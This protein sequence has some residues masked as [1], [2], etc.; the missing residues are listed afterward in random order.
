MKLY[1]VKELAKVAGVSVRT[2]HHYDAIGLLK[3]ASIG[4]NGYR[5]YGRE[6]L[7]RLQQILFYRELEFSLEAISAVLDQPDFDRAAA[8][9]RHRKALSARAGRY[10]RLVK[11]L[12]DTLAA[13]QGDADMTD[14]NLF[15]GF[16]PQK[17]AEYE[18]WMVDKYGGDTRQKIDRSKNQMAK[19]S[20]AEKAAFLKDQ[21]TIAADAGK[22]LAGG[23]PADGEDMQ[24]VMR[25]HFF[26]IEKAWGARPSAEAFTGL[27]Q[28]YCDHPDLRANYDK[29]EPG[30]AEYMAAGMAAYAERAMG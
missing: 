9:K 1:L 10:R 2:L 18:A 12:D 11:T 5:Y 22:A 24:K 28:L 26:W 17:Q 6:E 8:L 29:V 16:A 14:E 7:L 19:W 21:K 4:E 30:L 13:L 20:D 15:E 27:G 23:L 25:R 3:P